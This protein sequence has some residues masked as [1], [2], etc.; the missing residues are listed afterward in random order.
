LSVGDA[1]C[2]SDPAFQTRKLDLAGALKADSAGVVAGAGR[3]L[4]AFGTCAGSGVAEFRIAGWCRTVDAKSAENSNFQ[5]GF[6]THGVLETVVPLVSAGYDAP[7]AQSFQDELLERVK[8]LPG[9]ESA[10]IWANDAA[11]LWKFL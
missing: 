5:P 10:C 1:R 9:V 8:A 7:R 2:R 4:G 11:E 3:A 6:S